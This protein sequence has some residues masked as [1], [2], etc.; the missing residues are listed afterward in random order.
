VELAQRQ[1][2]QTLALHGVKAYN[3]LGEKFDP[4][5]HEA[6]YSAPVPEPGTIIDVLKVGYTIKD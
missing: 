1:L 5:R 2:A 4:N 6:L 3:R